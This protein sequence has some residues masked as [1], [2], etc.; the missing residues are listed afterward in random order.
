MPAIRIIDS[1]IFRGAHAPAGAIFP[2][3]SADEAAVLIGC[4]RAVRVAL[5]PPPPA[6]AVR[7][8]AQALPLVEVPEQALAPQVPSKAKPSRARARG[9]RAETPPPSA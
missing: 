2:D 5:V 7:E 3:A 9:P 8:T 1:T 6:A 4:G